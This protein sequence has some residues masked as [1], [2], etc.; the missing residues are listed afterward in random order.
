MQC[1]FIRFF[2]CWIS[3]LEM[4]N[5]PIPGPGSGST[6]TGSAD[7]MTSSGTTSSTATS[8]TTTGSTETTSTNA[9]STAV[10]STDPK[11]TTSSSTNTDSELLKEKRAKAAEKKGK[12][13][14]KITL[15]T[16]KGTQDF[17]PKEMYIRQSVINI[18]T[19]A[20]K[21]HGAEALDTPTMELLELLGGKYGEEGGKLIYTLEEFGGESL[22]LRYDLTVPLARYLAQNKIQFFKRWQI[23]KVF[24]RD[25]PVMTK[26]RYREFLQCDFDIAGSY[27]PMVPEAECLRVIFEVLK[28]LEIGDFEIRINHRKLLEQFFIACDIPEEKFKT[29]CSSVDKLD[30]QPWSEISNEL[31]VQKKIDA[32]SVKR[33]ERFICLRT[34][35]PGKTNE[36]LLE[37][38]LIKHAASD[39]TIGDIVDDLK[40]LVGYCH[41]LGVT[42]IV[43]DTCLARGLDYYT[44]VIY[45]AVMKTSTTVGTADDSI[46]IGSV[47]AGGRYDNL[48]KNLAGRNVPC[49]GVSFGI[50]RLF[51]YVK[52]KYDAQETPLRTVETQVYVGTPQK[53]MTSELL[54]IARQLWDRGIKAEMVMK[55]NPKL[56][57]QMHYCEDH[58]IPLAVIIGECELKEGVVKIRNVAT[59]EEVDVRREAMVDELLRRLSELR[60]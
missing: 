57:D 6:S 50:E 5:N 30:K 36:E 20:F 28:K 60:A 49:C 25:N 59:R 38:L 7:T 45:E 27:A 51:C 40:D 48:V 26:G 58:H 43:F 16:A 37:H 42:N 1:Q 22:G 55:A 4:S 24:R 32:D 29:V 10:C 8:T 31:V 19:E 11:S 23:A 33:L 54:A 21:R 9:T 35:H 14:R 52:A 13:E 47:A 56:L 44:G 3:G 18:C 15:K 17:A 46:P 39:N 2:V 34:L 53:E 41:A 12:T